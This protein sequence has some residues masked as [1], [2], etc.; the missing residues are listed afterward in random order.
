M[1]IRQLYYT[2]C[3]RGLSSGSGFQIRAASP[4][5]DPGDREEL[6]RLGLH[7]PLATAPEATPLAFRAGRLASGRTFV[8][9]SRYL[10]TDY[11]GRDGNFF[12]HSLIADTPL[13]LWAVDYYEWPCWVDELR[14]EEGS[15]APEPLTA[16]VL[17]SVPSGDSFSYPEL[18]LFL[19]EVPERAVRLQAMLYVLLTPSS[20]RKPLL[21]RDEKE[22]NPFWIACL[23]KALPRCT[24]GRLRFSTFQCAPGVDLDV[25]ATAPGSDFIFDAELL[26][27]YTV[28]DL[29][30]PAES[31]LE[32]A[33][34]AAAAY[35]SGMVRLLRNFPEDAAAFTAYMEH[36]TCS[37]PSAPLLAG[38]LDFF[39]RPDCKHTAAASGF[40]NPPI[41]LKT[42]L[43]VLSVR[44]STQRTRLGLAWT[45]VC[46]NVL[47]SMLPDCGDVPASSATESE[48]I[49]TPEAML[50]CGLELAERTASC[51][52]EYAAVV[53]ATLDT[54]AAAA[55]I[56]V[57]NETAAALLLIMTEQ[58]AARPVDGASPEGQPDPESAACFASPVHC[59]FAREL[60][61]RPNLLPAVLHIREKAAMLL[62]QACPEAA[63][64]AL[65]LL[66]QTLR[67]DRIA[68]LRH[69][70]DRHGAET[71]LAM[72]WK[73]LAARSSD[74]MRRLLEY[75]SSL[76]GNTGFVAGWG[77]SC[78]MQVLHGRP[79]AIQN[80]EETE[81]GACLS[82]FFPLLAD[83]SV[84]NAAAVLRLLYRPDMGM[85]Y[86]RRL[87]S[88]LQ[89]EL[90]PR[91]RQA[92][93][94]KKHEGIS[95]LC[96]AVF[97][98]ATKDLAARRKFL[99]PLDHQAILRLLALAGKL[100]PNF[101]RLCEA[102]VT[103]SP[104][105]AVRK[106]Q[107]LFRAACKCG[108]AQQPAPS[109][110]C[111]SNRIVPDAP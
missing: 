104:H 9:R 88:T 47:R 49:F 46:N 106:L 54:Q 91:T 70:L 8:Q 107:P 22:N 87:A 36:T 18:G 80:L 92:G 15:R 86:T 52:N 27:N 19:R 90:D 110:P 61:Y 82:L 79:D 48:N 102:A 42:L 37:E 76:G 25:T 93:A 75:L 2:C 56:P 16:V 71:I 39:N 103:T 81:Y 5:I 44:T 40:R 89:K 73:Y 96:M 35:A 29:T 17:P 24:A 31:S 14:S 43:R 53:R 109:P 95:A 57:L 32:T 59:A 1:P 65:F 11:S 97:Q 78:L 100:H 4:G 69:L 66:G 111:P 63:G 108:S 41:L 10:G 33:D 101:G 94:L 105:P 83:Q 50:R 98:M 45:A 7:I 51:G 38:S 84:P 26:R 74:P 68:A 30:A 99:A 3:R 34:C 60:A 58:C 6:I 72:E 55:A 85:T 20:D 77:L 21:I 64:E 13:A 62:Q 12:T 28:F 67:P 23:T